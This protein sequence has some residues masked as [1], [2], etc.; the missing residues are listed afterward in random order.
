M[1]PTPSVNAPVNPAMLQKVNRV[2]QLMQNGADIKNVISAFQREGITPQ[3]AEQA[4]CMAFPQIKQVKQQMQQS[5]MTPQQF[6][7][8]VMK[9]NNISPQQLGLGDV[10]KP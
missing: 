1:K 5:G 9:Q 2:M 7:A 6:L 3:L 8:Q 10:A 4:L